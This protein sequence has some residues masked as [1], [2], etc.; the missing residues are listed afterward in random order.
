MCIYTCLQWIL[1]YKIVT[2]ATY[3]EVESF[4]SVRMKRTKQKLCRTFRPG[5]RVKRC[6]NACLMSAKIAFDLRTCSVIVSDYLVE[7]LFI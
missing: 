5:L 4:L 7:L 6:I 3:Q 2:A 1:R